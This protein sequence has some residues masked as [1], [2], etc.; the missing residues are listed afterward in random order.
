MADR[1]PIQ[2]FLASAHPQMANLPICGWTLFK[3]QLFIRL[4]EKSQE[5]WSLLV[6]KRYPF[7][8]TSG[9]RDCVE[10]ADNA[11]ERCGGTRI[12]M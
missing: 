8:T 12:E 11:S 1:F 3:N 7:D 2:F 9:R 5:G 10:L 4:W 6:V